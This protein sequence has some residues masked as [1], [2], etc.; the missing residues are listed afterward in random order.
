LTAAI[1]NTA[2]VSGASMEDMTITSAKIY[3]TQI[4][5]GGSYDQ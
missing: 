2:D 1:I 3:N 4:G 5:V